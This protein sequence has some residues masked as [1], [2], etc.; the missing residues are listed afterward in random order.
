[1]FLLTFYTNTQIIDCSKQ[2]DGDLIASRTITEHIYSLTIQI[3]VKQLVGLT[4][5]ASFIDPNSN[6]FHFLNLF[7]VYHHS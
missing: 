6:W 2:A 1:M 3:R 7:S 5:L 4:N